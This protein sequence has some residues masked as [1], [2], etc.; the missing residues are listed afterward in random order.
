MHLLYW[1]SLS[2]TYDLPFKWLNSHL[3]L[4]YR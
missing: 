4:I 1:P 2:Y 3:Q